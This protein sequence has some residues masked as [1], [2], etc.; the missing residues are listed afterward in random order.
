M[1]AFILA[2]GRKYIIQEWKN[3]ELCDLLVHMPTQPSILYTS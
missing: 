2:A 3:T 1:C